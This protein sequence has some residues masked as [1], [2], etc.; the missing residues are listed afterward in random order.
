MALREILQTVADW[1]VVA[2]Q[3]ELLLQRSALRGEPSKAFQDPNI[4]IEMVTANLSG[5]KKN[6]APDIK[7]HIFNIQVALREE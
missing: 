3:L 2:V 5:L 4:A 7:H 6:T 1:V